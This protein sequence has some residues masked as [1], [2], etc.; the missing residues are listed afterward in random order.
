MVLMKATLLF[1]SETWVMTPRMVQT[2]VGLH[3][4]ADRRLTGKLPQ[5]QMY[6]VFNTPPHLEDALREAGMK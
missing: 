1:G 4:R 3:H 2:L 6:G 5:H